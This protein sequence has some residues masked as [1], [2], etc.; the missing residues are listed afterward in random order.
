M[1]GNGEHHVSLDAVIET[2]RQTGNDMSARY[3]ETGFGGWAV[4]VLVC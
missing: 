4:N 2:M 3:K 1:H